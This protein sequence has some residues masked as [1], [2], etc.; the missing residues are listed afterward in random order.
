M[1]IS[2]SSTYSVSNSTSGA[3]SKG[4]NGL[5]SGIDT[6]SLV[7]QMLSGTQNKIDKQQVTTAKLLRAFQFCSS[8]QLFYK[9]IHIANIGFWRRANN[10]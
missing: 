5:A 1:S 4:F 8:S 9:H 3:T 2:S 10:L 7:E 6:D